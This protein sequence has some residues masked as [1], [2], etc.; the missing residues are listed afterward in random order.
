LLQTGAGMQ[1]DTKIA[2]IVRSDLAVWQ[3]LNVASFLAGGLVGSYPE[4]AGERYCDATGRRYGPLVRQPILIFAAS[5]AELA[6]TLSRIIARGLD[7]SLYTADLFATGNDVD[8]RAAVASVTTD[9]L[10]LVG[11]GLHAARKAVDKVTKGLKL[12][13][14]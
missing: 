9:G 8:N 7:C 3:K 6:G 2:I 4:L 12:H 5:G 10:D 13:G 11:I 14:A 1:F